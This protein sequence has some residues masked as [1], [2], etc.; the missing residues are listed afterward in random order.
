MADYL[1]TLGVH[2]LNLRVAA[3][4][5][6]LDL[7]RECFSPAG[8]LKPE[9]GQHREFYRPHGGFLQSD[10][11]DEPQE[12]LDE[13]LVYAAKSG[14]IEAMDFLVRDGADV[15]G[16]PYN[17]T[18]LGWAIQAG[19]MEAV[20][21][22]LEHGADAFHISTFGG[23]REL[24]SLHIAAWAGREDIARLLVARGLHP[25]AKEPRYGGTPAGWAEH[26]G[27]HGVAAYLKTLTPG[28]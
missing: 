4:L 3:G 13:A 23:E 9:A 14:R 20:L 10:L 19:R 5:G 8:D 11:K 28:L 21:W 22:L 2:P 12:I 6:R 15:N 18:P 25:E 17:G 26:A 27:H 24:T 16:E 7:L 1:A